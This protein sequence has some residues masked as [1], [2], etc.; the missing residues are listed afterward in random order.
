VVSVVVNRR[1][2]GEARRAEVSRAKY[3]SATRDGLQAVKDKAAR[4]GAQ[5]RRR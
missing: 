1:Y 3:T 2:L 5:R 4:Q